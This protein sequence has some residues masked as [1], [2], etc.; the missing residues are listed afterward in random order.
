MAVADG[1]ARRNASDKQFQEIA[2]I[3]CCRKTA[4]QVVKGGGVHSAPPHVMRMVA[5]WKIEKG[6]EVITR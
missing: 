2:P 3:S 4:G 5:R 6:T 1:D